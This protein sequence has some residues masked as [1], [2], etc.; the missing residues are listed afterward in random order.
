MK[1]DKRN[2]KEFWKLEDR[3]EVDFV[4]LEAENEGLRELVRQNGWTIYGLPTRMEVMEANMALL[5][6]R[7]SAVAPP[8]MV[9]LMREESGVCWCSGLQSD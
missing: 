8:Q 7:V 2:K 1:V 6:A 5:S 9:D 3:I 4:T